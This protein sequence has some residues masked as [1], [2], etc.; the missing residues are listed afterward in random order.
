MHFNA[1]SMS[2]VVTKCI[3]IA[4]LG[5]DP[6]GCGVY[7][8]ASRTWSNCRH[9]GTLRRKDNLVHGKQRVFFRW[10]VRI[11]DAKGSR[12]IRAITLIQRAKI[13]RD[14]LTRL[15]TFVAGFAVWQRAAPAAGD[16]GVKRSFIC[17]ERA[18]KPL[19][20]SGNFALTET[21]LNKASYMFRAEVSYPAGFADT[22]YFLRRF[23][24]PE[25][26]RY[27]AHQS[28]AQFVRPR[29]RRFPAYLLTF[30]SHRLQLFV[31]NN[32]IHLR[33][34]RLRSIEPMDLIALSTRGNIGVVT[35]INQDMRTFMADKHKP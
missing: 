24:L 9:R 22:G 13:Q 14:E 6:P 7:L 28:G 19:Q 10:L 2:G 29:V 26:I 23:H 34:Q 31:R 18:H 11:G 17:A 1:D 25:H 12:H 35:G 30:E 32:V 3:A 27:G 20:F 15:N 21:G 5:N 33:K 16:N 8:I 4:R